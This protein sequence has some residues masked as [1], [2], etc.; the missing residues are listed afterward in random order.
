M[1]S[2]KG[3][4]RNKSGSSGRRFVTVLIVLALL[5]TVG[6]Y[7]NRQG[8]LHRT[9]TTANGCAHPTDLHVEA[10]PELAPALS[11]VAAGWNAKPTL[12]DGTCVRVVVAA[13][14]PATVAATIAGK[15]N[16]SVPGL[17][18]PNGTATVP[19]VWVPDSSTWL[20][21]LQAASP[22]LALTGTSVATS[23][24]VIALPQPIAAALGSSLSSLDWSAL[25]G[26]LTGGTLRPGIVDPNVDAT[27]LAT[28]LTVGAVATGGTGKTTASSQAKL[29]G[30][31]RALSSGDSQLRDDLL[32]QFPRATD[33]STIARS[34]AAAPIPEQAL[35]AFNAQQPPVP[36]IGLYLKPAPPAL[37]YPYAPLGGLS[38]VKTH[39]ATAFAALLSGLG[40]RDDLAAVDLRAAD[41]TYGDAMPATAGMPAGPLSSTPAPV[42]AIGQALSTWSAVT[43]PGRMLAVI[44]VSG[45]MTTPVPTAG[46]APRETV[47]VA[48][49][50]A[51]LGLFDDR[52]S[53]GLWTFSTDMD[54]TKP[55][56]QLVPIQ[57]LSNGRGDMV[58]ALGTVVPIPHGNTGLY[59]TVLAAYKTV[60]KGWDPSRV[61]SIVIMTDGQNDNP[62]GLTLPQLLT[63]I[64]KAKDPAKPIEV[65][66]LGIGNQVDKGELQ[67]ITNATGG[68]V[69]IATDPSKIGDIFLQAIALRPGSAK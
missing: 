10:T 28:L 2:V 23:P 60:Q 67:K 57:P 6:W 53:L 56:K 29:V 66:A 45:S 16:V 30:A 5:G 11:K 8:W 41:G 18:Q 62:G 1:G 64:A 54:G 44:D 69:F 32:G 52:W 19:D 35:L 37:D 24:I 27:G 39:A 51:G 17:G 31:M 59:D 13:A 38:S 22:D 49:A 4:H 63:A 14:E 68:G 34:L 40:W 20:A 15:H 50:K 36:L 21:R 42:Q 55:Y 26:K 25:L 12:I 46:G 43:V 58:S 7:G 47:T 3:Q 33:A 61:N 65:I 9:G 48:A